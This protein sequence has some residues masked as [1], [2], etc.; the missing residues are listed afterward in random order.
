M[1]RSFKIIFMPRLVLITISIFLLISTVRSQPRNS[2]SGKVTDAISGQPL[3]GASIIIS[4]L[5]TGVVT[6]EN[7]AFSFRNV[8]AGRHLFEV[9]YVGYASFS[10]YIFISPGIVKD[11]LLS[12]S[13]VENDE[14]VVTGISAATQARRNPVPVNVVKKVDLNRTVSTN[15][16]DALSNK[17]GISQIS[18]GPAVSKP[19]IRGLGYNRV[20]VLNDGTRQEGQQWGDEHGIEIDEY[21]VQKVEILKGPASLMYGSDAMAGV[22]NILTNVPVQEG[23]FK[24]SV[25]SAYQ[26]NNR[27]RGLNINLG[28]NKNGFSWNAYGSLKSAA[29]YENKYDGKVYNSKFNEKNFGGYVGYNGNWGYSHLMIS[30]F[31]QKLGMVEGERDEN[32]NF[33]KLMPGGV[34]AVAGPSDFKSTDPQV[35]M[36][37]ISHFRITSDNSIQVRQNRLALKLGYQRNQRMEFGNPDDLTDKELYFDLNTLTYSAIV[38]VKQFSGWN[39]SVGI[40]GMFQENK[41]KGE[42]VL[43]PEYNTIDAGV[44]A[45]VQKNLDKFS[46]SGGLRFDNR[47]TKSKAYQEGNELKFESFTRSFSNVSGSAG[48]SYLPTSALTFKFNLSRGFRAPSIPELSSNGSH[49][50]T[51]RY[52]YGNRSLVSETSLQTDLGAEFNSEHIS[53]SASLF[54][55]S[56]NNYIFYR[57]LEAVGGSDSLVDGNMAFKFDQ[58]NAS[59]SGFEAVID[60]HPHPLDWLHFENTISFVRGRFREGIE[61]NRNIPFMPAAHWVSEI[62]ADFEGESKF[63]GNLSLKLQFDNTFRQTEVFTVYNTETVTGG[64]LLLNAGFSTSI[65]SKKK[66]IANIYFN[67]MNLT[68]RAYQHHLNRLKYTAENPLTGRAGVFNMGRNFSIKLEIPFSGSL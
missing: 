23:V 12:P 39:A 52:E 41:N 43:I 53:V 50:G 5:R 57:K 63:I 13:V 60:I 59:L 46:F 48:L 42:E 28:S 65:H 3:A 8:A 4:D 6:D 25:T 19:V 9:S 29:D 51:N 15:L 24:G 22:I 54:N 36:Q 68:D 26:T 20:I 33:L 61:G 38:H 14:V 45:F 58:R 31:N 10:E 21:S 37:E 27:L 17:P 11:F 2:V 66:S 64:Y 30:K 67:V 32:G 16:I 47:N 34:E 40:N 35:P 7:G 18:T 49:E 56:I 44:F 62:R 55:N 1:Q